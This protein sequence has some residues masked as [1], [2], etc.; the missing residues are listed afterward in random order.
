MTRGGGM[1]QEVKR[2]GRQTRI[3]RTGGT[4]EYKVMLG[5]VMQDRVRGVK[6]G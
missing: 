3:T 1:S 6:L 4:E 5:G 2:A